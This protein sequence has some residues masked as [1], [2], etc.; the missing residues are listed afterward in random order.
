MKNFI[1]LLLFVGAALTLLLLPKQQ[2]QAPAM[3]GEA[4]MNVQQSEIPVDKPYLIEFYSPSCEFCAKEAPILTDLQNIYGSQIGFV[5]VNV[6]SPDSQSL[7]NEFSVNG[8]PTIYIVR[9]DK[10]KFNSFEGFVP[11]EILTANLDKLLSEK[12]K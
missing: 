1:F 12:K 8:L 7:L 4:E 3:A 2:E 9:L 6:D 10:S 11:R 5:R